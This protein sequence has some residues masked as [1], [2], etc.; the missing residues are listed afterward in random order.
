MKRV[1]KSFDIGSYTFKVVR[2][3]EKT[4]E[5]MNEGESAYA[6]FVPDK[7]M[8]FVRKKT[9]RIAQDVLLQSFWHEYAHAALWVLRHTDWDN[10][11]VVD[12]LGHHL[13]QFHRSAKF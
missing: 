7:L 2:A 13:H 3:S 9:A 8:I 6:L 11:L 5:Q 10:E 1:P 12:P 4:I